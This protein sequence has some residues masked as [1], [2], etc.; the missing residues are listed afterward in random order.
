MK[1]LK[2]PLSSVTAP[3]SSDES[4]PQVNLV[5][6]TEPASETNL[7]AVT[8][9]FERNKDLRF[10]Y[11]LDAGKWTFPITD[12]Q[13]YDLIQNNLQNIEKSDESYPKVAYNRHFSKFH[14]TRKLINGKTQYCRWLVYYLSKDKVYCF[15]CR[16]F[17][18]IQTQMVKEACCGW[19]D[20]SRIL[21]RHEKNQ[22]HMECMVKWM[23]FYKRIESGK[24]ID[25]EN[26]ELIKKS[27]KY[28]YN[29]F[30]R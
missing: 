16:L 4:L 19:N 30:K 15:P 18:H 6:E 3:E 5:S 10:I 24:T 2:K 27:Q 17:S 12:S 29:L 1:F 26:E 22:G 9:K 13:R 25:D 11:K 28:W 23:E 21:H 14:F 8:Q 7:S 20:L